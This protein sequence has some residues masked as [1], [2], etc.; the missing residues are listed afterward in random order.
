MQRLVP[1]ETIPQILA[2]IKEG[3]SKPQ[4]RQI[5]RMVRGILLSEGRRT[6]E[7][8]RRALVEQVS[9]GSLFYNEH[10]PQTN[11]PTYAEQG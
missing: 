8:I 10:V 3:T 5:E 6:I 11:L 9:K 2:P 4:F 7:A 1:I